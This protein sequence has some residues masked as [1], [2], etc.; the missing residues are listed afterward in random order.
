MDPSL[1]MQTALAAQFRKATSELEKKRKTLSQ[2]KF[3][4]KVLLELAPWFGLSPEN[5]K[6]QWWGAVKNG[7]DPIE[8]MEWHA[9]SSVL[10]GLH[11]H[12]PFVPAE[13]IFKKD[14]RESAIWK[15]FLGCLKEGNGRAMLV[16]RISRLGTW[17]MTTLVPTRGI[18]GR[19]HCI[20]PSN[21][22][23]APDIRLLPIETTK[24]EYGDSQE[25]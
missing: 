12:Y 3:H 4:Y 14:L 21:N 22:E 16:F 24:E 18:P 11:V 25:P 9:G 5:V 6:E 10:A 2:R 13:S 19:L 1:K 15:V 20:I 8:Q 7:D 23:H 17:V